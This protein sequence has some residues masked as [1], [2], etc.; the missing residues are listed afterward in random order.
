MSE[1]GRYYS[2]RAKKIF[3]PRSSEEEEELQLITQWTEKVNVPLETFL[4]SVTKRNTGTYA[5]NGHFLKYHPHTPMLKQMYSK[6]SG[7]TVQL[8]F[9]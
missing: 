1:V 8:P 9:I 3:G 4:N 7:A 2:Y 5:F 6:M